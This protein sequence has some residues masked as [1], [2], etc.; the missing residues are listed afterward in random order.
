MPA[1]EEAANIDQR[2]LWADQQDAI[3]PG[4]RRAIQTL[5]SALTPIALLQTIRR[6]SKLSGSALRT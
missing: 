3:S 5:L 1:K 4:E 6:E 2:E